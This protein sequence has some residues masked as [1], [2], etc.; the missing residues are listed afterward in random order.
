LLAT[1]SLACLAGCGEKIA[2]PKP[3]G[4]FGTT[5]YY[6]DQSFPD[7]LPIQILEAKDFLFVLSSDGTLSRR[8]TNYGLD[9]AVEGLLAPTALCTNDEEDVM[10][11]WEQAVQRVRAFDTN[12][13]HIVGEWNLPD[14]QQVAS[15]VVCATGID[16]I[17]EGETFLYLSDQ[18]SSVVHRYLYTSANELN[19]YGILTRRYKAGSQEEGAGVRFVH[20]PGGL[21]RDLDDLLLVCDLDS[22]RNW[23]I[24]FDPTPDYDDV[25]HDPDDQDPWRGLAVRFGEISCPDEVAGD[26]TLGNA[27]ECDDQWIP[28]P[29][30]E[31]GEFTVP[32]AVV[33][34]GAGNIYVADTDNDRIQIFSSTG[35]YIKL[36]GD[37]DWTPRPT[38]L[39]V[40]D[41]P[42]NSDFFGGYVFV[43]V[44][45]SQQI[46]K[47]ISSE[48]RDYEARLSG[49]DP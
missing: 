31:P 32:H 48:Q 49:Q 10:F 40:I 20:R 46:R 7:S 27:E 39:A 5:T 4:L 8:F 9:V 15:M 38:S 36:F 3:Q 12:E 14:V 25:T 13:L 30:V 23:V 21:A 19:P 6:L 28:G 1:I 33:L 17:A 42:K 11:V 34:D 26:F 2:I 35:E 18:D 24:R 29:S 43:V 44:P 47:F 41:K 37:A 22:V 45:D 16:T